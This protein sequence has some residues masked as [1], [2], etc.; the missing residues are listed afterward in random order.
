MDWMYDGFEEIITS[1][2]LGMIGVIA[3]ILLV[4]LAFYI[5]KGYAL[6]KMANRRGIENAWLAFIP[7][8]MEYITGK[9]VGEV[10]VTG[11]FKIDAAIG[12]TVGSI[13]CG[14]LTML[15]GFIGGIFSLA[16]W[17]YYYLAYYKLFMS[18][19]SDKA[20]LYIILS[21]HLNPIAVPIILFTLKDRDPEGEEIVVI[22]ERREYEN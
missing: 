3:I 5:L 9:L 17:I 16:Y 8:G 7:I 20:G 21:M 4:C 14:I 15:L 22:D 18:Y 13:L 2:V 1:F 10:A 11:T 6:Y 19:R 12:L